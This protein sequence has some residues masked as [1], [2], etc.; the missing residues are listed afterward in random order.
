MNSREKE[1]ISSLE[2]TN[3]KDY[4]NIIK[5]IEYY[6][7][8]YDIVPFIKL[9]QKYPLNFG[10]GNPHC[11]QGDIVDFQKQNLEIALCNVPSFYN[12]GQIGM[13][14][15]N[16]FEIPDYYLK[17][18]KHLF[19][20]FKKY[21]SFNA[22][23]NKKRKWKKAIICSG[24]VSD[25]SLPIFYCLFEDSVKDFKKYFPTVKKEYEKL[26]NGHQNHFLE[27]IIKSL[28]CLFQ[29]HKISFIKKWLK[30]F[31]K[32]FLWNEFDLENFII[33]KTRWNLLS[34]KNPSLKLDLIDFSFI[35]LSQKICNLEVPYYLKRQ[36][37]DSLI[38]I[39]KHYKKF[40]KLVRELEEIR[41]KNNTFF[42]YKEQKEEYEK[43]M[44]QQNENIESFWKEKGE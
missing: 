22:E 17:I 12:I 43:M 5:N 41:N 6:N 37:F 42:I 15:C 13:S 39:L 40:E 29:D 23:D 30:I 27:K 38:F 31:Q 2:K 7:L 3:K 1:L 18:K 44:K 28:I 16:A 14:L 20:L 11:F 24:S 8:N 26:D 34:C 9:F 4:D 32:Y 33:L 10:S 21:W 25:M 19:I 35:N 36:V